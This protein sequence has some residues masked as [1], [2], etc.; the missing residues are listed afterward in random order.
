M[1]QNKLAIASVSLGQHAAHTLPLKIAAAAAA[2][3]RGIEITFPDL[4]FYASS[5]SIPL[6][7]AARRIRRVCA[8]EHLE[9]IAFAS[10]QN[11]EGQNSPLPDRLQTA[12]EWLAIASN[13]GAAH[14]QVPSNYDRTANGDR[15]VIASE[16]Q[17][18]CDLAKTL[19]P[20]VKIA[21]E[22]LGWGTHCSLWQ[23]AL[24]IVEDVDRDNFGLCLDSFHFC[25]ALWGDPFSKGGKQPN[26]DRKLKES[27]QELVKQLPLE[28]LFYLQLSDGE[29]LDPP[30]SESHPWYDPTLDPAHVWSNEARPF[31]L[32]TEYCSYMP[33]QEITHAFLVD[34]G[35]TG[36]V[37]LETFDRRMKSA[38]QDPSRNARRAVKSWEVLRSRLMLSEPKSILGKL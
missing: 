16:L 2:G 32:E 5:I 25:A 26:G 4:D 7:E 10:F 17:Q 3:I 36:W 37:S 28:K 22:N 27:L 38:H 34:L 33:V 15:H 11:Y 12:R 19:I 31:P 20:V 21:Y 14:L 13:L 1:L 6:L 30:Y 9:I 29:L 23:H 18:L 24:Q 8:E 35:Y